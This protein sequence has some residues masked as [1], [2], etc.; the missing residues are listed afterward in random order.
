MGATGAVDDVVV[1]VDGLVV[2]GFGDGLVVDGLVVDGFVVDGFVAGS[3]G[4]GPRWRPT[5]SST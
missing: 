2:D 3:V 4:T 5:A 1:V